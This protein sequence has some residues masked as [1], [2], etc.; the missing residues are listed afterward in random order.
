[1]RILS[2]YYLIKELI[3]GEMILTQAFFGM[4][5]LFQSVFGFGSAFLVMIG[6]S[7]FI[8]VHTLV[9]ILLITMIAFDSLVVLRDFKSVRWK[10]ITIYTL[11]SLPGL[12]MGSFFLKYVSS[13]GI[14]ITVSAIILLHSLYSL[15]VKS[16]VIPKFLTA[17][18]LVFAG[19][20]GGGS[21]LGIAYVPLIMQKISDP[22]ELRVSLNFLWIFTDFFMIPIFLLNN[23]ITPT[24]L[25]NGFKLIP[26]VLLAMFLGRK[27]HSFFKPRAYR[28]AMNGAIGIICFIRL[29]LEII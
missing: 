13:E 15:F 29:I 28:K 5:Y 8:P 9:G 27:L 18:L 3:L 12:Y 20:V 26:I 21:M 23:V 14:V 25:Q 2:L 16:V 19:V 10:T 1:M 17:P 4:A 22:K 6:L 7:I 24:Q 11:I